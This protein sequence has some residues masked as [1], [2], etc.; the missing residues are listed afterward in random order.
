MSMKRTKRRMTK[1][2]SHD[3]DDR[4]AGWD[5]A[6]GKDDRS[7]D[8]RPTAS[9][10]AGPV[11]SESTSLTRI[12]ENTRVVDQRGKGVILV[13]D[14]NAE[15]A[16]QTA[17]ALEA[18]GF[19]CDI[20]ARGEAA[21]ETLQRNYYDVVLSA[22]ETEGIGG[23]D[24]I[25][26]IRDVTPSVAIIV[27]SNEKQLQGAVDDAVKAT[28]LGA[29]H[30]FTEPVEFDDLLKRIQEALESN[31]VV[32]VAYDRGSSV[33]AQT[34]ADAFD[35]IIF[36][37]EAIRR[38]LDLCARV[39]QTDATVLI[40]GESGTGKDLFARGIHRHSLRKKHLFVPVNCAALSPQIIESEL[41]GHE[42]GAFTGA[43]G[44]R[45]GYFEHSDNGTIFLDE[46]GDIPL[47]TQ[48]KLLRVL[49][50]RE[51]IRVGSNTPIPVNVRIVSATHRDLEKLVRDGTF[52]EDLYYRLK[53]VTIHLPPLRER[54]QDIPPLVAYFF[55][56]YS[57]VYGKHFASIQPE[58]LAALVSH[59]WKGNVR[60]LRHTIEN[61]IVVA[62]GPVITLTDLPTG[63][64]QARQLE[65]GAEG[66]LDRLVGMTVQDVEREL[67]KRTL[68]AV[69]GNRQEAARILGIAERTLYR[70][71]KEYGLS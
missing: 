36:N 14:S 15:Q 44:T 13:V 17:D 40:T 18:V 56:H 42:K 12:R 52:R 5:G 23:L 21:L 33:V 70:R 1:T 8:T 41:F 59:E 39:A 26:Q 69:A 25:R 29:F 49:E 3:P 48:V 53:V 11:T 4:E 6:E 38:V 63:I 60:E 46:V 2:T 58:A 43:S 45:V 55:R 31:R 54:P 22:F 32:R 37:S 20:A 64:Q 61:L 27:V 10:S 68:D 71:L 35:G 19:R 24:L 67:I 65:A 16:E 28:K 62:S 9:M 47:E 50:N 7:S 51:I 66:G 57:D 30:C 34:G